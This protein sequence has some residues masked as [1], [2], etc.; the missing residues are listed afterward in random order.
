MERL[1]LEATHLN[2]NYWQSRLQSAAEVFV[3]EWFAQGL[4]KVTG[5]KKVSALKNINLKIHE[6]EKIG[7]IGSNG[8]G[9]STL[10]QILSGRIPPSSGQVR[11]H[12][13]ICSLLNLKADAPEEL[14][15][16]AH[17]F[18]VGRMRGLQG[19]DLQKFVD[20]VAD[21]SELGR[22]FFQPIRTYSSGMKGRLYFSIQSEIEPDLLF[23]DEALATGDFSF[24]FKA[25]AKIRNLCRS[26][27]ATV[28]V[29]HD[30]QSLSELADRCIWI[31]KGE[32][33]DDGP[34]KS[35]LAN[36]RKFFRQ[37]KAS[38]LSGDASLKANGISSE[39]GL[40]H[41]LVLSDA[42]D[43]ETRVFEVGDE[44]FFKFKTKED[45][46]AFSTARIKVHRS[47]QVLVFETHHNL[48]G[49]EKIRVQLPQ[50][51]L[52]KGLYFLQAEILSHQNQVLDH[53]EVFFEIENFIYSYENPLVYPKVVYSLE[54]LQS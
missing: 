12:S 25:F 10:L 30:L 39:W 35:V 3:G 45:L 50:F 19:D 42:F 54:R 17:C 21:F 44:I 15:G 18:S 24:S 53:A 28:I 48:R 38:Q 49:V 51:S 41:S 52:G 14:S 40:L 34:T 1:I 31:E 6:C 8:A 11:S 26:G 23:I 36:Y 43:Q 32:I 33:R 5:G 4:S 2:K 27:S 22:Y 29:S 47:D 20:H 46:P 37:V 13:P 7:I 9:K 16:Q